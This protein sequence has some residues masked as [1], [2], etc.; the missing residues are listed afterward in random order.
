VSLSLEQSLLSLHD[1]IALKAPS[2][3]PLVQKLGTELRHERTL[4]HRQ[5]ID[6]LTKFTNSPHAVSASSS[7]S[8]STPNKAKKTRNKSPSEMRVGRSSAPK[9]GPGPS[10]GDG[11]GRSRSRSVGSTAESTGNGSHGNKV[12]FFRRENDL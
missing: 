9:T 2:L 6:L 8:Y 4:S 7:S 11:N 1:S 12:I 10:S 5:K 3:L